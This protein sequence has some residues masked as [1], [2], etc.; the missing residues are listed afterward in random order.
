[1]TDNPN[2]NAVNALNQISLAIASQTKVINTVFPT[3]IATSLSATSGAIIPTNY[4]GFLTIA[5]PIGGGT[6]KVP[7]YAD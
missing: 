5:N 6:I 2:Q 1:M 3:A 4:K 7:F